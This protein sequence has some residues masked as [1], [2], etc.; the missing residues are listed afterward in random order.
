MDAQEL[1][2]SEKVS[3]IW[4]QNLNKTVN[5]M[6]NTASS[7]IGLKPKDAIELGTVPVDKKYPE[8]TVLPEDGLYRYLYQSGEQY[9]DQK[10]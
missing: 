10:R 4:V 2:D 9:G 3:T 1:Q 6:N 8:K 7:M 5:K